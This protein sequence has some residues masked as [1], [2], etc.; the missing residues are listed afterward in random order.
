MTEGEQEQSEIDRQAGYLEEVIN[1]LDCLNSRERPI[2]TR[3]LRDLT[4]ADLTI[5]NEGETMPFNL[6]RIMQESVVN[7]AEEGKTTS[8]GLNEGKLMINLASPTSTVDLIKTAQ[9]ID[10]KTDLRLTQFWHTR[11]REVVAN[12]KGGAIFLKGALTQLPKEGIDSTVE[13]I[14]EKL[15]RVFFKTAAALEGEVLSDQEADI[16]L[17]QKAKEYN[18]QSLPPPELDTPEKVELVAR[19]LLNGIPQP[20][21]FDFKPEG[22]AGLF[23]DPLWTPITKLRPIDSYRRMIQWVVEGGLRRHE[24]T[25]NP[26]TF[27]WGIRYVVGREIANNVI[28]G[29]PSAEFLSSLFLREW[30]WCVNHLKFPDYLREFVEKELQAEKITCLS[31]MSKDTFV[32]LYLEMR[33]QA[34]LEDIPNSLNQL[35]KDEQ[36]AFSSFLERYVDQLGID[37]GTLNYRGW[38]DKEVTDKYKH[39]LK[40]IDDQDSIIVAKIQEKYARKI[41]DATRLFNGWEN[42]DKGLEP[43]KQSLPKYIANTASMDCFGRTAVVG[44]SLMLSEIAKDGVLAAVPRYAGAYHVFPIIKLLDGDFLMLEPSGSSFLSFRMSKKE[45]GEKTSAQIKE[46]FAHYNRAVD[47]PITYG[48][49]SFEHVTIDYLDR[50]LTGYFFYQIANQCHLTGYTTHDF[51]PFL[52]LVSHSLTPSFII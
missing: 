3:Q 16:Q 19:F 23:A 40:A 36:A 10:K 1:Y 8:I 15:S 9:E 33:P 37:S 43:L 48:K 35:P 38:L 11:R 51:Y 13:A 24:K 52:K 41:V 7:I 39:E 21:S 6:N 2:N 44:I 28:S 22:L 29:L 14:L 30:E 4:Q 42:I 46:H 20:V 17:I 34:Q 32:K 18:S 27:Q 25:F 45:W 5:C 47:V 49:G 26:K 50:A 12:L 31:K